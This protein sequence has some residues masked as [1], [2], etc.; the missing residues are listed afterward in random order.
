MA[1]VA[2][3]YTL[4]YARHLVEQKN[5]SL[6]NISA[7]LM[8]SFISNNAIDFKYKDQVGAALEYLIGKDNNNIII[9]AFVPNTI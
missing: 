3:V 7:E 5:Q 9:S 1:H 8:L 4:T 2:S 6:I